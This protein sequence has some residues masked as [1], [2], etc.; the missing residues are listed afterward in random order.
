MN[1]ARFFRWTG[2]V[3]IF[4]AS[5]LAASALRARHEA[6]LWNGLK[7]TAFDLST[8]LPADGILGSRLSGSLATPPHPHGA[9]C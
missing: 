2:V 3:V 5:G 7:S 1:L 9:K 8:I 6:G 4:L